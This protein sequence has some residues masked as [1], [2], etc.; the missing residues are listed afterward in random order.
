M[1]NNNWKDLHSN[2]NPALQQ[3]WE[4]EGFTYEQVKEWIDIGLTPWDAEFCG[5]LTNEGYASLAVLNKEDTQKLRNE[6]QQGLIKKP[7]FDWYSEGKLTLHQFTC[8]ANNLG[9][10]ATNDY[11]LTQLNNLLANLP[12]PETN[13]RYTK[14]ILAIVVLAGITYYLLKE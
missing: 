4:D 3:D 11:N 7:L 8:L 14:I 12:T 10:K 6:Y 5:W 13:Y 2:F 9:S 1:P